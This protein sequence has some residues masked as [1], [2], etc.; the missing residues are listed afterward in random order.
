[1]KK[2]INGKQYDTETARRIATATEGTLYEKKTGEFFLHLVDDS[3]GLNIIHPLTENQAKK[4]ADEVA[5]D[6][7]PFG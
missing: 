6:F 7:V 4:W 1:M 3:I 5:E 2:I